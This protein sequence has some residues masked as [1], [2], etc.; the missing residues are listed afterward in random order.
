MLGLGSGSG[1]RDGPRGGP[2]RCHDL[3]RGGAGL[4]LG[5]RDRAR[6]CQLDVD[7]TE[8]GTSYLIATLFCALNRTVQLAPSCTWDLLSY[9]PN[10]YPDAGLIPCTWEE[11]TGAATVSSASVGITSVDVPIAWAGLGGHT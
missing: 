11:A 8:L 1:L 9:T 10:P 2:Y 7:G 5:L 4:G 6:V 3:G